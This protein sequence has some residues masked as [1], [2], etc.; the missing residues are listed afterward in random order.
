M[1]LNEVARRI[2]SISPRPVR[3]TLDDGTT[4]VFRLNGTEF[5]QDEFEGEGSR[6]GDSATY[7]F[8]TTED[9]ESVLV[10]RQQSGDEGWTIVGRVVDVDR[11]AD[12]DADSGSEPDVDGAPESNADSD[13]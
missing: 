13:A 8:V 2:H 6:D 4:G 5:F 3:L 1:A 10:G 11:L 12:A 9:N 7:R